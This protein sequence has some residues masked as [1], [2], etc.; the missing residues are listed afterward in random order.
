MNK[1]KTIEQ[2]LKSI[3]QLVSDAKKEINSITTKKDP[4]IDKERVLPIN[5]S[6][7]ENINFEKKQNQQIKNKER[8]HEEINL[9]FKKELGDWIKNN[10]KETFKKEFKIYSENLIKKKLK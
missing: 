8:I 7:F 10:L 1:E 9:N 2:I 6:D 4:Y 5:N 3:F